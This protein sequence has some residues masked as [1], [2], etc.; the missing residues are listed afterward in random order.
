[1]KLSNKQ[2]DKYSELFF[3]SSSVVIIL[4]TAFFLYFIINASIPIFQHQGIIEFLTGT[5]WRP[6]QGIFGIWI[7]IVGTI[8]V[9]LT[10]LVIV[11]PIGIFTAIFLS[12]FAPKK[13]AN[14][15]RPLI[16]LLVGIPS[17]IYGI[18]GFLVLEN[19]FQYH[20]NPIISSTLGSFI[21]IFYDAN[22]DSGSG[23]LLTST[24]LSIMVIPTIVSISEDSIR[25]VSLDYRNASM[26][27]GATHWE[28]IKKVILPIATPGIITSI[29]LGMLRSM[30]EATA[31][32]MI[33][34][35]TFGSTPTSILDTS[36][37]MTAI[38]ISHTG[39]AAFGGLTSSALFGVAVVLFIIQMIFSILLRFVN[40]KS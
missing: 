39:E 40:K 38:I 37:T 6:R 18:L 36:T 17:V 5:I 20:I 21:P 34:G 22:P 28:T 12:E 32:V 3:Y 7:F 13:I 8:F 16:E 11:V 31:V 15:V 26:A 19:I 2:I 14:I 29:I 4:F 9:T 10:T 35:N 25:A 1:M 27:L 24:I 30:S 33:I 23:I